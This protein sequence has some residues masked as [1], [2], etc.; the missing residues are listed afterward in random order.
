MY[1]CLMF[2]AP[3]IN[4]YIIGEKPTLEEVV[5]IFFTFSLFMSLNQISTIGRE[6]FDI[7]MTWFKLFPWYIG[8]F[9]MG[10]FIDTYCDKIPISNKIIIFILG[11]ILSLSCI[12][13]FYS[14][15][16][17][18]IVKDYLILSNTGIL[19][20]IV[21]ISI[22]YLFSKNRNKFSNNYLI[23]KLA[24]MS[25]GIY[26]IHLFFLAL[27]RK[28]ITYYVNEPIV[29]LPLLIAMTFVFSYLTISIL[30]K[31]K[32]FKAVS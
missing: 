32:W 14:A 27:F 10:Y 16:T 9:I 2:F 18:G 6:V 3:F 7:K 25:F 4:S 24:S 31:T 22:F 26:L 19:T 13:N 15:S 20:F 23:S 5:Y 1:I 17:L 29:G 21:T 8:Y 11:C 30:T 28:K 12:L